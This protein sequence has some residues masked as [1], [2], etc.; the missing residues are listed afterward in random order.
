MR[1]CDRCS[2]PIRYG[3]M[4]QANAIVY[5][6]RCW[7]SPDGQAALKTVLSYDSCYYCPDGAQCP[8]QY[9]WHGEDA[10]LVAKLPKVYRCPQCMEIHS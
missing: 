5:C 7:H 8:S 10:K 2:G 1:V 3:D 6:S 4:Y 9:S